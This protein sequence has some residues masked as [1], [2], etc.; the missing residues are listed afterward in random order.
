MYDDVEKIKY[1]REATI[2][3]SVCGIL[4]CI[5]GV[6]GNFITVLALVRCPKLRSQ[7]TTA[8]VLSLCFSDLLFCSVN[9]PLTV[10]RYVHEAWILGNVLCKL[11]PVLFYGNVAAS[12]LSMVA[13][14]LNRY[15]LISCNRYYNQ[16]YS[17]ASICLQLFFCWGFSFVIMLP[18]LIGIWGRMG[19]NPSTFSCTILEKDG[20]SPKK[21]I[22]LLGFVLPCVVIILSYSCIY[23]RVR[24]SR[25]K[26][27]THELKT[28]KDRRK[29]S[30]EKEDNRLTKLMLVI[31]ICFLVCFLPLM[32]MNV[33][34]DDVRYPILHVIASIFAW[35]S[36]V[37]NPFIYAASNRQYRAAYKK[38]FNCFTSSRLFS[39][40]KPPSANSHKN[41]TTDNR[42][43]NSNNINQQNTDLT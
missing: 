3:A 36:S 1:P 32:L 5:I 18:P 19:L 29:A 38:L 17:T 6:I 13:I 33:F 4:F 14:T 35:A 24:Q 43:G 42:V 15:I 41:C 31:F 11:F 23:W 8:F 7:A 12:L 26:L 28:L 9:L 2:T 20:K 22:F 40:E 16:L 30:R 25:L 39:D 27:K 37:I 21:M 10:S 34:D